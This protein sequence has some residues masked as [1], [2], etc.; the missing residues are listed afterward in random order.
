MINLQ[1]QW[2]LW[3]LPW[4]LDGIE[5]SPPSICRNQI[6]NHFGAFPTYLYLRRL[7]RTPNSRRQLNCL[8]QSTSNSSSSTKSFVGFICG[9]TLANELHLA[10]APNCNGYVFFF[11]PKYY[12]P[13]SFEIYP[14]WFIS[15]CLLKKLEHIDTKDL[16]KYN[17]W[18]WKCNYFQKNHI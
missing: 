18:T 12:F 13:F 4:T 10:D 14:F 16:Y 2:R 11:L 7:H 6:S 3:N 15:L 1:H 8:G 5:E 17:F 9:F